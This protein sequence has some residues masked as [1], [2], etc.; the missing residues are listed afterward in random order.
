MK[1]AAILPNGSE[2]VRMAPMTERGPFWNLLKDFTKLYK[3]TTVLMP[4]HATA[5]ASV[6]AQLIEVGPDVCQ[7]KLTTG[8]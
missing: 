3:S 4:M 6:E 5:C 2:K 1:Y 8:H 7:H